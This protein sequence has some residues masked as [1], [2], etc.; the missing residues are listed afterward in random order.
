MKIIN[1]DEKRLVNA[2]LFFAGSNRVRN[3]FKTKMFKL[4]YFLDFI[5]FNQTGRTVTGE[6]YKTFRRG[7]VPFRLYECIKNN[8]LPPY[9]SERVKII[10]YPVGDYEGYR[11]ASVRG[12]KADLKVFSK[13]EQ[14]ILNELALI[15]KDATA[16]QM[17]ESTHLKNSPWEITKN[18]KGMYKEIDILLAL[19]GEFKI[20]KEIAEERL[21]MHKAIQK[22]YRE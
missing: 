3:P 5:H 11:F 15:F 1:Q 4:L 8:N 10:K 20:T 12:A 21:N 9:F 14:K 2:I 7:P 22:L 17:V 13:R 19:D 6:T 18:T 16:D